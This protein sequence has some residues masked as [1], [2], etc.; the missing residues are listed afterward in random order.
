MNEST[1][2]SPVATLKTLVRKYERP[3]L[4]TA[5]V[6][7]TTVAVLSRSGIHAHNEFLKEHGLFDQFYAITD[8]S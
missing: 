8:E 2:Q 4:I 5:T 1:K 3:I 6:V 7:S